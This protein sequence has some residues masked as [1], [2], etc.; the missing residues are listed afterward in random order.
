MYEQLIRSVLCHVA[1]FVGRIACFLCSHHNGLY[2]AIW[3]D[4][5]TSVSSPLWVSLSLVSLLSRE[6]M[7]RNINFLDY[8][9]GE[10]IQKE[11][12]EYSRPLHSVH[13]SY[14]LPKCIVMSINVQPSSR[15][16]IATSYG[17]PLALNCYL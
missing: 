17:F 4:I 13:I 15:L 7:A 16:V 11:D 3:W 5:R 14:T 1:N 8:K 2:E 10:E 9:W 6:K 12:N